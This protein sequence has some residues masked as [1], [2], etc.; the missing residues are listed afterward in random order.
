[1]FNVFVLLIVLVSTYLLFK[2]YLHHGDLF[3]RIF[4]CIII[5]S[6]LLYS[7]VGA[8]LV[9]DNSNYIYCYFVY[10]IFVY[11]GIKLSSGRRSSIKAICVEN[12]ISNYA[13]IIIFCFVIFNCVALIYP[14][15]KLLN[16]INPPSPDLKE[17]FAQRFINENKPLL[18]SLVS[19]FL[20]FLQPFFYLSLYY[21]R[22][23]W[24]KVGVLLIILMYVSYCVTGYIGRGAILLNLFIFTSLLYLWYPK[25]R[26]RII[27]GAL[28]ILPFLLMFFVYYASI[29]IGGDG[30]ILS[31]G[32]IFEFLLFSESSYPL[33]FNILY[34]REYFIQD[35]IDYC[36]WLISLPF[37]ISLNWGEFDFGVNYKISELLLGISRGSSNFYVLLP[38]MIGEAYFVFRNFFWLHGLLYGIIIGFT[39]S[40]VKAK[41]VFYPIGI[42]LALIL[43]YYC[44]RGGTSGAYPIILKQFLYL[45]IVIKLYQRYPLRF[46]IR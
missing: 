29:R 36:Y 38:G 14:E 11:F 43:G 37:P 42:Y 28:G 6:L 34:E 44:T 10:I 13:K 12:F 5:F 18:S 41:K 2:R 16:L 25:Y 32:K 31:M 23:K 40:I 3:S 46:V 35:A 21:Y 1:M 33:H 15:N 4:F 9:E 20:N 8:S 26:K 22:D 19:F 7:G 30:E 17:A 45:V 39:Y 27:I 24:W